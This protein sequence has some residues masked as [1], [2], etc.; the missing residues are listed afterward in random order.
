[1]IKAL[2]ALIRSWSFPNDKFTTEILKILNTTRHATL[3]EIYR[4]LGNDPALG[5]LKLSLDRLEAKGYI[6][7]ESLG[8][9]DP[10]KPFYC[11]TAEGEKFLREHQP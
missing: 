9:T 7:V 10:P 6:N 3:A 5:K 11:I 1:M 8:L 2:T 4:A